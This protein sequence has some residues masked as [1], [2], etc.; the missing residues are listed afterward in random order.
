[1]SWT[2]ISE[3]MRLLTRR[4][5]SIGLSLEYNVHIAAFARNPHASSRPATSYVVNADTCIASE[6]RIKALHQINA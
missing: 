4:K 2:Y 1:M 6:L 5:R 3:N